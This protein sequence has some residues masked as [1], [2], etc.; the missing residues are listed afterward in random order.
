[1]WSR[2][3]HPKDFPPNGWSTRFSD[4][5]GASHTAD[6][7]FWKYDERASDGLRE[8]AEQGSTNKL[9]RE[10]KGQVN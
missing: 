10:L 8:L 7:S 2:H 6:Y 4:I 5:I 9:E 1:M 3:T